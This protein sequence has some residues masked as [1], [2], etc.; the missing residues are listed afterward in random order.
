MKLRK[1]MFG[2]LACLAF[3][4]CSDDNDAVNG[5]NPEG[6]NPDQM[7]K[8][9]IVAPVSTRAGEGGPYIPGEEAENAVSNAVFVFFHNG[10]FIQANNASSIDFS[11]VD[12][13]EDYTIEKISKAVVILNKP[14]RL[15]NQ[16]VAILNSPLTKADLNTKAPSLSTLKNLICDCRNS[17]SGEFVMS[18]SVWSEDFAAEIT[19]NNLVEKTSD[20]ENEGGNADTPNGGNEDVFNLTE[21]EEAKLNAVEVVNI[22][23]ERVLAKVNVT[24]AA[25]Q[26][27]IQ[28]DGIYITKVTG[29]AGNYTTDKGTLTSIVPVIKG[30]HLS[31]CSPASYLVKKFTGEGWAGE[32]DKWIDKENFR[33]YWGKSIPANA[34]WYEGFS[35]TATPFAWRHKQY[36]NVTEAEAY[37]GSSTTKPSYVFY[38]QEN[39]S[40]PSAGTTSTKLVITAQLTKDG[41]SVGDLVKYKGLYF[42]EA[43]FLKVAAQKLVDAGYK[44][45]KTTADPVSNDWA[46]ELKSTRKKDGADK[47][48]PW[49]IRVVTKNAVAGYTI[50]DKDGNAATAADIDT[51]LYSEVGNAWEWQDGRCYYYVDIQHINKET[52]IIRNHVY[53]LNINGITGM[54]T[55]VYDPDKGDGDEDGEPDENTKNDPS[56]PDPEGGDDPNG[57]DPD[58][59]EDPII[60]EKP[61]EDAFYVSAKLNILK[62]A[63]VPEQNVEI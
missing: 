14:V 15:P 29:D 10:D 34:A 52:A 55:P 58:D 19:L 48:D 30:L 37:D 43:D 47:D 49:E 62:W 53:Q 2:A 3:A 16:V 11:E 23:V 46:G 6:K 35:T 4:A 28:T 5:V 26:N 51:Y 24:I 9:N 25:T 22:H 61:T 33:S 32:A 39:T 27:K 45:Q 18:N 40:A 8:I 36:S 54:G 13:D 50:T 57:P 60:P 44:F 56:N 7:V 41:A 20:F 1:L 59:D 63:I 21:E 17:G 12:E 42:S 38:T 31:Y